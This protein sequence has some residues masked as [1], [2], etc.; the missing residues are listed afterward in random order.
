VISTADKIRALQLYELALSVV[1]AKGVPVSIGLI[2]LREYRAASLTIH[3]LPKSGHLDLWYRRKVLTINR[4]GG[5][6]V[7]VTHYVPGE[8]EEELEAAATKSRSKR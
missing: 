3:Y 6:T 4:G 5:G 8:W 2:A 7:R 1:E